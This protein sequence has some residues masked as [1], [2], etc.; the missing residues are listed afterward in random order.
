MDTKDNDLDTLAARAGQGD[1]H[2]SARLRHK[3]EPQLTLIVRRTLRTGE[4]HSP[5]TRC[6][7]AEARRL[8]D[9][10]RQPRFDSPELLVAAVARRVCEAA[11]SQ[12]SA[13]G[14]PHR[15]LQETVVTA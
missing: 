5:L 10:P 14:N 15:W 8:W 12:L 9:D 1:R 6:V 4:A 11:V 2:A 7:L 13:A 3:L